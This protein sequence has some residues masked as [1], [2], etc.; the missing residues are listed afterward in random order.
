MIILPRQ[1]WQRPRIGLRGLGAPGDNAA[2]A[3]Q[4]GG[5][6]SAGLMISAA[7]V[8]GPVGAIIGAAAA[9]VVALTNLF[10]NVFSGCGQTCVAATHIVDQIEAQY[11]KPNLQNYVSQPVRTVSMQSAALQ[12]FDYAWQM[13]L[14]GC[15]D[16][17]LG[18][19]GHRC[20]ADR[21]AGACQWKASPGQWT[22]NADGS[23]SWVPW[24]PLNSGNGCFNWFSGYRDPIANDP[25]VQP[26]PSPLSSVTSLLPSQIA[27]IPIVDLAIPAGLLILA[28]LL[29]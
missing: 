2:L 16:P 3:K 27:G 28:L 19:A 12:V 9:A 13:V 10:V 14:Q 21:Q 5:L 26:D 20:I 18:E 22:Q 23:Y 6:A 8:G 24:G 25:G 4:A 11:L 15:G 17:S 7:A 29:L 1:D